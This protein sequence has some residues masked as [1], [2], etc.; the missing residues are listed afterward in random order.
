MTSPA[1][2]RALWALMVGNFVI[3][4]GVM[5]VPGTLND[6]SQSLGVSIPQAGQLITAAAILM[7]LGAPLFATL[8]AGWDRRRLLAWSLVWYGLLHAAC[9]LA[10][11]YAAL[12]PLRVLAVVAPAVFTPQAAA[13]VGLLVAD[14]Q[15]GRAITFVFLGWSVAS[16]MGMP[17]AAWIGGELGWRWAFALVAVMSL[18]V[19][20]WVWRE[21]PDGIRPAALSREAWGRTLG[22]APLMMAVGVTLLS[23]FGQFTLFS[24]FAP[25][26]AQTLGLGGAGL[27]LLFL[28][29]GAFGLLGNVAVTRQIDRIGAP[30]AVLI[31]LALM[32]ISLL[33]WPLGRGQLWLQALVLVPWA[34]GCFAAN[35]AQQARLV[36]AAPVLAPATVALNTSAMYGGQAL[37]A[38]LGGF[39]IAQ[40][41]MLQLH[42][43]GLGVMGAAI[44]TSLWAQR[45]AHRP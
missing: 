30:R 25:Y 13:S 14:H 26:F 2:P 21:M 19:G 45:R 7:G 5:V 17:L 8:V 39:M 44:A 40:G 4:T 29:F 22:S 32:A 20:A 41:G 9:A 34:L 23:A 1:L 43:V 37:G 28:W 42:W 6:I 3:G 11:N 16:V 27:S 38:A 33:L 15:R 35:S 31:T 10:P 36:H 24:Y 12:L 18:A